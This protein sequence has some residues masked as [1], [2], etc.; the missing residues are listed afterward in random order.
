MIF[1]KAPVAGAFRIKPERIT[2]ERGYF[3]RVF[4]AE[5]F[6]TQGLRADACQT[7]VSFNAAVGTLRGMHWQAPPYGECKLIRC[8]RGAVWDVVLDLR[9]DSGT[10]RTWWSMEL[11]ADEGAML[12]VPEGVAHGFLT[13]VPASEVMYQMTDAYVPEAAR[14]VRWDDPAFGITWPSPPS[15][16]SERDRMYPD[17]AQ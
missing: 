9:P 17:F 1:E 5:E 2:D 15:V 10:Y 7:S 16:I 3:A 6:R 11:N 14:G 4:D 12:Y 8:V 13:L